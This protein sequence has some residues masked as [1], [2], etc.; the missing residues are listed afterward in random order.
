MRILLIS[1]AVLALA[2]G[3]A[4][5]MHP[6]I[7]E[8]TGFLGKGGR[9]AETGFEYSQASDGGNAYSRSLAA[10]L[11]YGLTDKADLLFTVPWG[12]WTA[13]G[14]SENGL[15]DMTLDLKFQAA[16]K[17]GWTLALKPGLILAAGDDEKG[18]GAGKT[19]YALN[20]VAGRVRGPWQY[21]LNAG[22]T[23]NKNSA[24]EKE[25]ILKVSAAAVH[26]ILP[27]ILISADLS[28]ETNSDPAAAAHP[29]FSVFGVVWSPRDA[30][31][32]DAGV[33]FGLNSAAD[34]LGLLAGVTFR[35]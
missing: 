31:D 30:L 26:E 32:L 35:F 5:A 3:D 6:L 25:D 17:Y 13:G 2:G 24:G 20:A 12:G 14:R 29:L 16:E 23:L 28:A 4:R 9:Q 19:A 8:D 22:Y 34:D 1:L 15:G 11:S 10:E 27:K 18:L 33:K 7:S 21:Y